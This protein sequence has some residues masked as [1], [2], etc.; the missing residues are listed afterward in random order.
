MQLIICSISQS[1][2]LA[3]KDSVSPLWAIVTMCAVNCLGDALMVGKLQ[4]GIAGIAWATVCA[5]YRY[6]QE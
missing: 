4:L 5:Q 1:G 3:M 2:L 6:K